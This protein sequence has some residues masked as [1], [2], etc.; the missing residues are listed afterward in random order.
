MNEERVRKLIAERI[1]EIRKHRCVSMGSLARAVFPGSACT[2]TGRIS[3]WEHGR[4][5]PGTVTL[6]RICTYLRVS[7][8][9]I[10]GIADRTGPGRGLRWP[11]RGDTGPGGVYL[12]PWDYKPA[13]G[14]RMAPVDSKV[15]DRKDKAS[16]DSVVPSSESTTGA[17]GPEH[18]PGSDNEPTGEEG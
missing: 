4:L 12:P 17:W 3:D 18:Y 8:D 6:I 5:T 15:K 2:Q 9:Y 11:V 13:E 7:A 14:L 16:P 10:L 1:R